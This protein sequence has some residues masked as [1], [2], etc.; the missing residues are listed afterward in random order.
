MPENKPT[1]ARNV[2]SP[3]A[4]PSSRGNVPLN[5]TAA[6]EGRKGKASSETEAEAQARHESK[7]VAGTGEQTKP[8]KLRNQ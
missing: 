5:Q 8:G 1:H 2:P 6:S 3:A 4:P 7:P